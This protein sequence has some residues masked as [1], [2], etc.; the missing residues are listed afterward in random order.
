MSITVVAV[1]AVFLSI[2]S[3]RVALPRCRNYNLALKRYYVHETYNC[4]YGAVVRSVACD[5][6]QAGGASEIESDSESE[7]QAREGESERARASERAKDIKRWRGMES[8][9]A[10]GRGGRGGG[11]GDSL[12]VSKSAYPDVHHIKSTLSATAAK[13]CRS[14]VRLHSVVVVCP[15]LFELCCAAHFR[16][17]ERVVLESVPAGP[18]ELHVMTVARAR[19][20]R[21]LAVGDARKHLGRARSPWPASPQL[22][23]TL[24]S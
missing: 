13:R 23:Q 22:G 24:A 12:L 8:E 21:S 10:R 3:M 11:N 18:L 20:T 9:R 14:A 5:M 1:C 6:N 16:R 4:A 7:S 15:V 19:N 17:V 2:N